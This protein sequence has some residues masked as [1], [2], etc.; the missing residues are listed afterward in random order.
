MQGLFKGLHDL[1]GELGELAVNVH[2]RA[3]HAVFVGE[4]EALE[5]NLQRDGD[6]HRV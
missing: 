2:H 4:G 5:R 3:L 6:K 1:P